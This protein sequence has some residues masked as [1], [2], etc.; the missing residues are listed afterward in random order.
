ML[1]FGR[2][3]PFAEVGFVDGVHFAGGVDFGLSGGL[4]AGA[5]DEVDGG[6]E[7]LTGL[8][9]MMPPHA[10]LQHFCAPGQKLSFLQVCTQRPTP[11]S[12]GE[13]HIPALGVV[14]SQTAQK[15]SR[16]IMRLRA[17]C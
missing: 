12:D 13:G 17:C 2:R 1:L 10:V 8:M 4:V 6:G 16:T 15:P 11:P 14:E 5:A 9:H 7:A 3:H